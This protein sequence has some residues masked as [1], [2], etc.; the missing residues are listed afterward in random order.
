[1]V[2]RPEPQDAVIARQL[3]EHIQQLTKKYWTE[4]DKLEASKPTMS[5]SDYTA[6]LAKN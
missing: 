4:K 2:S 5:K 6:K 1:M 3:D